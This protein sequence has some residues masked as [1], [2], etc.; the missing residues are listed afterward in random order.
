MI[1]LPLR[2]LRRPE[3]LKRTGLSRTTIH[4]LEAAGDFPRHRLITPRCAVWIEHEVDEWLRA[5]L[6]SPARPAPVP[7]ARS[8]VSDPHSA[9][10]KA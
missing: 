1:Q 8:R 10:G 6:E 5:R 9:N 7:D 4:N 2:T 3:V